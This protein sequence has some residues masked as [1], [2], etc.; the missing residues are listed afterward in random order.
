VLVRD[1]LRLAGAVGTAPVSRRPVRPLAGEAER[2]LPG[3]ELVADAKIGWTHAITIDAR[4]AAVWPWL[5]QMGCRRAGWYSYDGLDNG[6][7]P[8]ADRILPQ[9]QQVQVG[10]ILPQTPEAEDRFVVRVVEPQRALVLGD[11]AGSMSW[12]FVLEPAG[13]TGTRLITRSRG[14][15]DRLALG[16]LLK[17]VWHPVHL[18][19]QRRQLL[20]LKR[21]VEAQDSEQATIPAARPEPDETPGTSGKGAERMSDHRERGA[22]LPPRWFIRLFWSTHRA[23][24]RITGGR[25]GLWR[26]K[27]GRW[28][29]LRLTTTGRRTGRPRSVIVGYFQDG[30]NLVTLAMN[31]W[32]DP[33]PAWWLNL[34]T[35]PEAT[36]ELVG[37]THAVRARAAQGAERSR[38][39]ARWSEID[40]Q[41]DAYAARRSAPTAVVILE[42]RSVSP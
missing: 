12:A 1:A 10:D 8:S 32:A 39:W 3:D 7:V 40:R 4:P 22:R 25:L 11:D 28:G 35:Q 27:E 26:P 23:V 13:E 19:M 30:P 33:E 5:V 37:E 16:L 20:N 15:S 41:L 2:S 24:Y 34:Q 17:V 38:L 36:V 9:L 21:L 6:G 29:T 31:G 42:P 18:G 14:A